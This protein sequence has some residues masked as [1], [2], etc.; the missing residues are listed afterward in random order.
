MALQLIGAGLGRT[1]TASLKIALEALGLGKCY[2]MGEVLMN[3]SHIGLWSEAADGNADW[4]QLF[5][6][7]GAAVDYPACAFWRELADYY[8]S[9]KVLLSVRDAERW[10]ESTQATI[11]SPKF[12][13]WGKSSP[14]GRM[15][16]K[17]VFADFGDHRH[18]R[19]FMVPYFERRTEEIKAALPEDRLLVYEVK[20]GWEPLCE[21][22]G[23]PVPDRP[24]PRVNSRAETAEMIKT[25]IGSADGTIPDDVRDLVGDAFGEKPGG[26]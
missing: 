7:Y 5:D 23:V 13:E 21:F 11:F 24:F 26:R 8:P 18:D 19:D 25:M 17:A 20:Q 3:Q 2:H 4:E 6:G 9:A 15:A 22:L 16:E 1:G 12:V 10:F 14:F